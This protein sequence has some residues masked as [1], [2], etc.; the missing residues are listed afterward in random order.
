MMGAVSAVTSENQ[1]PAALLA[2]APDQP[3]IAGPENCRT[4]LGILRQPYT[5]EWRVSQ[6][7]DWLGREGWS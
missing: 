4:T 5:V 2:C 1:A 7:H 6:L 3:E